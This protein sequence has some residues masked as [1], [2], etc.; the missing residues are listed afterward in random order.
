MEQC[1]QG[2]SAKWIRNLEKRIGSEG[3]ARGSQSRTRRLSVDCSSCSRGESGSPRAGQGTDWERAL[4]GLFPGRRT[5]DSELCSECQSEEIQPS[6]G[7]RRDTNTNRESVA[8]RSFS[9]SEFEARGVRKVT[10]GITGLWQPSVHS[11]SRPSHLKHF[12]ELARTTQEGYIPHLAWV[13]RRAGAKSVFLKP[14]VE[15][16]SLTMWC[17]ASPLAMPHGAL[18]WCPVCGSWSPVVGCFVHGVWFLV[19]DP[20]C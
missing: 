1:R 15:T 6:A 4:Q 13:T 12:P 16:K 2:K 9:P 18:A 8:Y 11:D 17:A 19:R 3:W 5:V 10:T 20:D 14:K 7:K